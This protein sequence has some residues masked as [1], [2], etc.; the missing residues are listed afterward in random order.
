MPVQ[1]T[2]GR[3]RPQ[4]PRCD[5]LPAGVAVDTAAT[6]GAV[7][8]D[9]RGRVV[10]G[11]GG[12]L[13]RRSLGVKKARTALSHEL[14]L[15]WMEVTPSAKPYVSHARAFARAECLRIATTV[16]G[17]E[18]GPGP[19]S[20]V[21]SASLQLA[22]SRWL[23]DTPPVSKKG[24][25]TELTA[26]LLAASRLADASRQNLLTAYELA[27]REAQARRGSGGGVPRIDFNSIDVSKEYAAILAQ[28][29]P[30]PKPVVVTASDEG[31]DAEG[32]DDV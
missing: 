15:S 8:R 24:G 3:Q 23:F 5:E 27:A 13:A 6:C 31:D 20:L 1:R 17:G 22:A 28:L 16:G 12:A 4:A 10:P 21:T 7:K 29:P 26:R 2:H 9:A 25:A 30:K 32:D 18:C 11:S 19:A 14:H